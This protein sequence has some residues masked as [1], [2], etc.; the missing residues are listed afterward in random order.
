MSVPVA[1]TGGYGAQSAWPSEIREFVF[2]LG[3]FLLSKQDSWVVSVLKRWFPLSL[4]K[5]QTVNMLF[6]TQKIMES[7]IPSP[8]K[9]PEHCTFLALC[10][11]SIQF[12]QR[13]YLI[14]V[15]QRYS[16]PVC[17]WK[18]HVIYPVTCQWILSLPLLPSHPARITASWRTLE[19]LCQ[20]V[21]HLACTKPEALSLA[22]SI[23]QRV[24][25]LVVSALG[26]WK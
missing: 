2:G 12:C 9:I 22:P 14:L 10:L 21:E 1:W 15:Y 7:F 4:F 20:L 17:S 16:T 24:C 5:P 8:L 6:S 25:I 19:E 11:F 26:M 18:Q 23:P 3:I 13:G